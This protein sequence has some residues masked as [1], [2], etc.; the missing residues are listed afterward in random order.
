MNRIETDLLSQ[1]GSGRG[2]GQGRGSYL[3]AAEPD[4][5]RIGLEMLIR[6]AVCGFAMVLFVLQGAEFLLLTGAVF[7]A[8][9]LWPLLHMG[10]RME[11][12]QN[13]ILYQGQFYPI[14]QRTRVVWTGSRFRM[15][16]LP[17]TF[18]DISGCRERI[19]VSFM[20]EAQ[21]LFNRAYSGGIY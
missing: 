14:G 9:C 8:Y 1:S 10:D 7:S 17:S 2:S 21:K 11:F 6:L 20:Q 3:F 15:S 16:F 18:L 19:D 13:G 4:R 5:R 12:Y